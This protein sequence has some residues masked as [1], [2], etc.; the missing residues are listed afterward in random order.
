MREK[1]GDRERIENKIKE[2]YQNDIKQQEIC[3][4]L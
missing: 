1:N 2:Q 4:V 3:T